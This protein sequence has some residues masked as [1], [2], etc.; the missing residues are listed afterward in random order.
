MSDADFINEKWN[1]VI[2]SFREDYNKWE[3]HTLADHVKEAADVIAL[4]IEH[5][6]LNIEKSDISSYLFKELRKQE[7]EVSDRTIQRNL[8]PQYKHSEKSR[9]FAD[10]MSSSHEPVWEVISV[11]DSNVLV[12][13]DQ[14]GNIRV[15]GVLQQDKREPRE[16]LKD[17]FSVPIEP[18][19][20]DIH[21]TIMNE[22][23]TANTYA[24]YFRSVGEYYLD[25]HTSPLIVENLRKTDKIDDEEKEKMIVEYQKRKKVSEKLN[26]D[27]RDHYKGY[28]EESIKH[29]STAKTIRNEIDRRE[30]WGHYSKLWQHYLTQ[31]VGKANLADLIGYCSKYASIGIERNEDVI[32]FYKKMLSCPKCNEDI[33]RGMNEIIEEDLRREEE[34]L[35]SLL[36]PKVSSLS[37]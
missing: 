32:K 11:P 34:N 14:E 6:L 26:K 36:L 30:K 17:I 15:N 10:T 2:Q 12:E 4:K 3:K 5:N 16:S 24:A 35:P 31:I 28:L 8:P 25:M 1:Q 37:V 21:K 22:Y 20:D 27:I 7:I 13:Q 33:H 9:L 19:I 18:F 23:Q 29:I